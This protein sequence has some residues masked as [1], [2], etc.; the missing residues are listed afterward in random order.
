MRLAEARARRTVV[1]RDSS[2][3]PTDAKGSNGGCERALNTTSWFQ[4]RNEGGRGGCSLCCPLK[5]THHHGV[6]TERLPALRGTN[7]AMAVHIDFSV[8]GND[9]LSSLYCGKAAD[10][11]LLSCELESVLYTRKPLM[12]GCYHVN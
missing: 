12:R 11:G 4:G 8:D 7:A 5:K 10:V 1:L 6:F 2:F 9:P 3:K